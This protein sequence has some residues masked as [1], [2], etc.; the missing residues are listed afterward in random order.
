MFALLS[1][2]LFFSLSL[3]QSQQCQYLRQ[4]SRESWLLD[5][6]GLSVQ[7]AAIPLLQTILIMQGYTCIFPDEKA[8]LEWQPWLS[9]LVAFVGVDYLYYW[10]H[11]S[12]HTVKLFPIHIVHHTIT[13]MDMLGS[14]RNTLWSSLFIPYVWVHSFMLYLLDDPR[15]YLW[16][17]SLTY[18]LDL[19]RH[20]SL[21]IDPK[22]RIYSLLN[23]W[24]ILPQDHA[25][26]HR[27]GTM[28]NFGA[29][30]KL[31]DRLHQTLIDSVSSISPL[32]IK[33]KMSLGH[34]LFFPFF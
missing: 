6:L 26:H 4:K 1:F 16:G 22:S 28:G 21:N 25:N 8:C 11:R 31:W 19:W 7:G 27:K 20:S 15:G 18:L 23:S 9:F 2:W 5:C 30:L 14:S 24:L 33:L 17:I 34:K 32:G 12:L 3:L 10:A 13:Q 29:N